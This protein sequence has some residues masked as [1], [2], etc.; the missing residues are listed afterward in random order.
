MVFHAS[1]FYFQLKW[2]FNTF[3][4]FS[5]SLML[6]TPFFEP[7]V[8]GLL[9]TAWNFVLFLFSQHWLCER[10]HHLRFSFKNRDI[11]MRIGCNGSWLGEATRRIFWVSKLPLLL[12]IFFCLINGD[13][14]TSKAK[15]TGATRLLSSGGKLWR[16]R[17]REATTSLPDTWE[18]HASLDVQSGALDHC[19]QF[20]G[21]FER[22]EFKS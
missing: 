7:V 18:I 16:A 2:F 20:V 10:L 22:I 12:G 11:W 19:G 14:K 17:E 5:N 1:N 6:P 21:K 3:Y 15:A 13:T 4:N 9:W 8:V